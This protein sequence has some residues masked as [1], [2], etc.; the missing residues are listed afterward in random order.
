MAQPNHL[1]GIHPR[2]ERPDGEDEAALIAAGGEHPLGTFQPEEEV[3][4][5]RR[6]I[7]IIELPQ[8][9]DHR[10]AVDGCLASVVPVL[11]T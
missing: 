8:P 6:E 7:R 1:V 3:R 9:G 2:I 4:D 11:G 5:L 10:L